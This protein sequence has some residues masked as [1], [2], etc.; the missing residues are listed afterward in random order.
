MTSFTITIKS[1][2]IDGSEK[3]KEF[4]FSGEH[5]KACQEADRLV[6]QAYSIPTCAGVYAQMEDEKGNLC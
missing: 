2:L 5:D 1:N 6:N 3:T 4:I